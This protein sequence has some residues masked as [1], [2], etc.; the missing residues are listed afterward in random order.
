MCIP[1]AT[2]VKGIRRERKLEPPFLEARAEGERRVSRSG[3]RR[4]ICLRYGK[5][6]LKVSGLEGDAQPGSATVT[7]A[8]KTLNVALNY[9]ENLIQSD[10]ATYNGREKQGFRYSETTKI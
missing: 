1:I 5:C 2:G 9:P 7:T 3:E 6:R 10:L 4:C 8:R